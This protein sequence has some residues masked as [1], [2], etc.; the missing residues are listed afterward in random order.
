[1]ICRFS[2]ETNE[3]WHKRWFFFL[4]QEREGWVAGVEKM[5]GG[6]RCCLTESGKCWQ[7]TT[8]G[9]TSD[10][11]NKN[12]RSQNS[13]LQWVAEETFLHLTRNT[14]KKKEVEEVKKGK[15]QIFMLDKVHFTWLHDLVLERTKSQVLRCWA[16]SEHWTL[17]R[18]SGPSGPLWGSS[19]LQGMCWTWLLVTSKPTKD[20]REDY[21][22]MS[23]FKVRF[24][25]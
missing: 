14:M 22:I 25:H 24:G 10:T 2:L 17:K 13:K 7:R 5:G 16:E 4:S 1:M 11:D 23:A 15:K 8:S 3:L 19:P 20:S 18:P 9:C 12:C 21:C 6:G